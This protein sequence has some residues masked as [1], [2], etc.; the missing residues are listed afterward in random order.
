MRHDG[1]TAIPRL[2]RDAALYEPAPLRLPGTIGR[3]RTKEA[4][5]HTLAAPFT[6]KEARQP[7]AH[8]AGLL[9]SR[10]AGDRDRLGDCSVGARRPFRRVDPLPCSYAIPRRASHLGPCST[11]TSTACSRRSCPGSRATGA[12]KLPSEKSAATSASRRERQ[13]SDT[14]IACT[15]VC[16]L[17]LFSIV[18]LLAARLQ[19]RQRQRSAKRWS[20]RTS[21]HSSSIHS[22][23]TRK[24]KTQLFRY[25]ASRAEAFHS[26]PRPWPTPAMPVTNRRA[27][28]SS[29]S[30]RAQADRSS[31]L[32]CSSTQVGR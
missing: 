8:G 13:W 4:R 2:R 5:L 6:A 3:P 7:P 32:C 18:T 16:L 31:W 12:P 27:Q 17:G 26:S 20:T 11:P 1:I 15:M 30:S 28:R 22:L 9:R 29:P 19:A 14:T 10:H 25:W 23:L 24:T 21:V